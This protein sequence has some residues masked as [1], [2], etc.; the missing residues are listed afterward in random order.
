MKKTNCSSQSAP[1]QGEKI[2][3]YTKKG[4]FVKIVVKALCALPQQPPHNGE[5]ET[6]SYLHCVKTINI[7]KILEEVHH[8]KKTRQLPTNLLTE[9][10][11]LV[12]TD[13]ILITKA[14]ELTEK[15]IGNLSVT[16]I[17]N[18]QQIIDGFARQFQHVFLSCICS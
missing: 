8:Y 10:N 11:L 4:Y 16:A 9:I 17:S 5:A 14:L 1:T 13:G 6:P 3:S 12:I 18:G 15:F 2:T 7:Y